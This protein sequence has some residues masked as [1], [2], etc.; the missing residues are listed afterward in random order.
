MKSDASAG[1]HA[2]WTVFE[3]MFLFYFDREGKE[4]KNIQSIST[5]NEQ[6]I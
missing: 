1:D 6:T 2:V 3:C 4:I 5:I